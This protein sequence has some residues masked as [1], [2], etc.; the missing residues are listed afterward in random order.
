M[1]ATGAGIDLENNSITISLRQE[2]PNLDSTLSEDTTSS[3]IIRLI[4]EG[5][6][7]VDRRG[8]IVPRVA[9]SWDID[10]MQ[11]TFHLRDNAKWSYGEP[12]TAHDFVYSWRRLVDPKTGARG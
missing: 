7:G 1:P 11:V 10:V 5:L 6:V 2:P 12:V 4:N 8:Q 9:H 3:K